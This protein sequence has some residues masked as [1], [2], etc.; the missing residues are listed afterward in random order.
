MTRQPLTLLFLVMAL[1]SS[2]AIPKEIRTARR[3]VVSTARA[4][5]PDKRVALFQVD[6]SWK[7]PPLVL[8]G[9]TTV[10]AAK[11]WLLQ[12]LSD[13]GIPYADSLVVLPSGESAE[14]PFGVVNVSVCN[15]RSAPRHSAE[16]GTQA[17]MGAVLRV[18]KREGSFY[19]VQSPD[20][21]LGWL[22]AG[23]FVPVDS[24][25]RADWLRRNRLVC[26][27][28]FG[29]VFSDPSM[30]GAVVTDIVA[31]DILALEGKEGGHY[32]VALPDGRQ[33]WLPVEE[34]MPWDEWLDSRLADTASLLATAYRMMGR[35]YLWG[36]TSGKGMDCSGFTK[37]VYF[38]NGWQL[39]RDA[40]QQVLAGAEVATDT[41][42]IE[43]LQP[44]D[45]LFFGTRAGVGSKERITHV[46]MYIGNGKIIHASDMVEVE[47][48][49]R[50]DPGFTPYRLETFVRARRML[51]SGHPLV[52]PL[53]ESSHYR[54][55]P[56][57]P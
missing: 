2:C 17:L 20:D 36:G 44:G 24:A 26:T 51:G 6:T 18:W 46:A 31:G 29:F 30:A 39:P 56:V 48:L 43:A 11:D 34:G 27:A 23:A 5:A 37:M 28:D 35:P 42:E 1:L 47:S 21:Y 32:R 38:L 14:R 13:A 53:R 7:R 52:V 40:S 49:R 8:R 3:L 10:P 9:E 45:L 22:D 19:L 33:G 16:L 55:L 54:L 41:T 15:M 12:R 4:F 25:G 50:G 57:R